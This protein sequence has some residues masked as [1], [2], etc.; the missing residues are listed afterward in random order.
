[1]FAYIDRMAR[2]EWIFW[3]LRYIDLIIYYYYLIPHQPRLSLPDIA[4]SITRTSLVASKSDL[5]TL[6][7]HTS[8]NEGQGLTL[9]PSRERRLSIALFIYFHSIILSCGKGN[10]KILIKLSLTSFPRPL[11]T[12][13]LRS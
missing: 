6:P 8:S 5:G 11:E 9:H 2:G 10:Y 3:I 1:M 4:K 12:R 7:F 13:F